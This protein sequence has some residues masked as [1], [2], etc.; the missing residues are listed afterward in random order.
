MTNIDLT[1]IEHIRAILKTHGAYAKKALGQNFLVDREAL[2]KIIGAGNIQINDQILEIGPGLGVL[3]HEI[4]KKTPNLTSLEMDPQMIK[5]VGANMANLHTPEELSNW[6][7]IHTDALKY[8][9]DASHLKPN[10]KILANIPYFITSPLLRHFLKDQYLKNSKTIPSIIVFLIQKEVAEKI[11]DKR[12]E[13]VIGLNIKVFG[14]PEIISMVPANSF[15]PA[16]K[17]D[18]AILRITV[19]D[20]PKVDL[21]KIDINR[22]FELIERGFKSPRKKL[23]NNLPEALLN[24]AGIDPDLRA[25]KL[26]IED[27]ERLAQTKSDQTK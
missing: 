17:V 1:N 4:L 19:H 27:W 9:I 26:T 15:H 25:E 20:T 24:S 23:R 2:D 16:P 12:K 5:V 8:D 3:T 22:F 10:Y 7:L 14:E 11:T 13:S 18:S 6:Q 21:T